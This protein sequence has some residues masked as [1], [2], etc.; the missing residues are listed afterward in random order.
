MAYVCILVIIFT[1]CV[2]LEGEQER[3]VIIGENN[4]VSVISPHSG[5]YTFSSLLLIRE[6]I[7]LLLL[8][9]VGEGVLNP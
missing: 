6:E 2:S 5:R 3:D 8:S 4:K 7:A 1:P 9:R